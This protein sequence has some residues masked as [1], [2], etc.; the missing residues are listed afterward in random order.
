M[1]VESA[2]W[3]DEPVGQQHPAVQ[4]TEPGQIDPPPVSTPGANVLES[5]RSGDED[6]N[7]QQGQKTEQVALK[8]FDPRYRQKFDGLT[9]LGRL[10]DSFDVYGHWFTIRTLTIDEGLEVGL[11]IKPW[12]GT[13]ASMRAYQ[14]AMVSACTVEVDGRPISIPLTNEVSD[15]AL[16]NRFNYVRQHWFPPVLDVVYERYLLL[17]DE[18]EKVLGAMGEASR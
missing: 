2:D 14:A 10:E 1:L 4:V 11:V 7:Q 15:S 12:E 18:V 13:Q 5:Q 17:E 6:E 9:F 3:P 8:E 16:R